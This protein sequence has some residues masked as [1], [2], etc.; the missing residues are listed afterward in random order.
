[1]LEAKIRKALLPP[2]V[3]GSCGYYLNSSELYS[4]NF[5]RKEFSALERITIACSTALLTATGN[6]TWSWGH[7]LGLRSQWW[8]NYVDSG[9]LKKCYHIYM[10]LSVNLHQILVHTYRGQRLFRETLSLCYIVVVS[11]CD[12]DV[13]D[14]DHSGRSRSTISNC[15]SLR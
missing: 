9:H 12:Y 2:A 15:R 14:L 3:A 13:A 4:R 11:A 10:M 8:S 5:P 6:V 1:M 7:S